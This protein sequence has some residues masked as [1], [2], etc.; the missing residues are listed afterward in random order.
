M[1]KGKLNKRLNVCDRVLPVND[2]CVR[3]YAELC[4][5]KIFFSAGVVLIDPVVSVSSSYVCPMNTLLET[6]DDKPN[7]KYHKAE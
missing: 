7:K 2:A 3:L 6:D 4:L 1:V 5:A